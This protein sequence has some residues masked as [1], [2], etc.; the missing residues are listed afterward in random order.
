[1][2]RIQT[3]ES[4]P[5]RSVPSSAVLCWFLLLFVPGCDLPGKPKLGD[6]PISADQIVDFDVLYRQNCAG[7]HG[8]DGRLGPAPPLNDVVFLSIAPDSEL[9]RVISEGRPGTPM[10]GFA[11]NKGGPL[12]DVQVKALASGIKP[13]WGSTDRAPGTVPLYFTA[14]NRSSGDKDYG[15][16]VFDRACASCHG[17]LGEG[18]KSPEGGAG[19]IN[20]PAFLALISDQ[21]LRRYAITGRPDLGMPGYADKSGRQDDYQPMTSDEIQDLVAFLASWRR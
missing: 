1:V 12:T 15:A 3:T 8:L 20:E 13:R 10:P 9:L 7:C 14:N 16:A 2:N 6:K 21:A 19:A 18:N 17:P 5:V 4:R 11:S